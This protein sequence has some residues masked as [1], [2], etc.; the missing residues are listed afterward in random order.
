METRAACGG[1][2]RDPEWGQGQA[3]EAA[4]LRA[5]L[6]ASAQRRLGAPAQGPRR[7]EFCAHRWP[8]APAVPST[9]CRAQRQRDWARTLA[10][11]EEQM[12]GA[13]LS[14]S[15]LATGRTRA[16][17]WSSLSCNVRMISGQLSGS[18]IRNPP[19]DPGSKWTLPFPL[20]LSGTLLSIFKLH[21]KIGDCQRGRGPVWI[22]SDPRLLEVWRLLPSAGR[23][24]AQSRVWIVEA[25]P[26]WALE[27][28]TRRIWPVTPPRALHALHRVV[29]LVLE[30]IDG[31]PL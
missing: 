4:G 14:A 6:P 26:L 17:S 7:S 3:P 30:Q 16:G 1:C 15:A 31:L 2:S 9:R 13:G 8:P 27:G 10:Q 12:S 18:R 24:C 22:L 5:S 23:D 21:S 29:W 11:D 20:C 28:E 19:P 25:P